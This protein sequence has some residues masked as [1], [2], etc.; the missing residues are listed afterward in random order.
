MAIPLV[1]GMLAGGGRCGRSRGP[2]VATSCLGVRLAAYLLIVATGGPV[3]GQPLFVEVGGERGFVTY[4]QAPLM[5]GGVAAADIDDD[6][7]LDLFLATDQDDPDRVY[8]NRGDG[9]FDEEAALVGL[10][11]SERARLGLWIDTDGDGRLDLVVGG[12]CYG[13]TITCQPGLSLLRHYR[14]GSDGVFTDVT[15]ASGLVDDAADHLVSQHR[16]GMAAADLDGDGD[17]DLY[18]SWWGDR[19]RL[20]RNLGDG[21]FEEIGAAAGPGVDVRHH[22]QPV[23][24]DA[25][26]DGLPDLFVAIDFDTNELWLNQGGFVFE[27]VAGSVGLD[28]AWN[29]M[30][31]AVGD[32]DNDGDFDLYVTNITGLEA[33]RHNVLFRRNADL[34]WTEVA[35]PAG[36]AETGWGWGTTFGDVDGDGDLDLA[37]TNGF[38]NEPYTSDP[39][40]LFRNLLHTTAGAE[41]GT[42][43]FDDV[44][45]AAGVDD[46][47]WGNTILALDLDRDGDLDL[48]QTAKEHGGQA[49]GTGHLRL[50]DNRTPAQGGYLLVK[51][52][53]PGPN[54]RAIGAVVE[55]R[56]GAERQQRLISAGTSH[57]GQEGAEAHFGLATHPRVDRLTIHWPDGRQT[58]LGSV[59]A[60]QMLT[61]P[62]DG[63]FRDGFE[64][65]NTLAWS[66]TSP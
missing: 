47:Y 8:R 43:L 63:L 2:R 5:G 54:P 33:G 16:S 53:M 9:S 60:N 34:S 13:N 10:A 25:N 38:T 51:P 15:A 26:G 3:A 64:G 27:E 21:T 41:A 35:V 23:I 45:V 24:F 49:T 62:W 66:A 31:V 4:P 39:S 18:T 22:W 6:G 57:L 29:E 40:Y 55:I 12:D 36:V 37:V 14:Q 1:L 50:L 61:V 44:S 48:L 58:T 42:L 52:R 19:S 46:T 30:G 59:A 7:D 56:I 20:Y 17:L 65:G 11:S 32:P 28:T